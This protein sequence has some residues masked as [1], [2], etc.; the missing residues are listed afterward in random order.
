MDVQ[1]LGIVLVTEKH[2]PAMLNPDVLR[3]SGIIPIDWELARPPLYAQHLTQLVF[4]NGITLIAEANR[5]L[6]IE[7][8]RAK[9]S[10][11]IC[12]ARIARHYIERLP[13]AN[14]QNVVISLKGTAVMNEHLDAVRQYLVTHLLAPGAWQHF[15]QEP[16]RAS[17]NFTYTLENKRLNVSVSEAALEQSEGQVDPILLFVG[18]FA[19]PAS[20]H[21]VQLCHVI[22]HWQTDLKIFEDLINQRFLNQ[23]KQTWTVPLPELIPLNA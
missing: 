10:S 20:V 7:G 19:Y 5:I 2:T 15:G 18:T 1:E 8:I 3:C 17:L 11:N 13:H 21:P 6:F 14:Y 4:Q 9:A 22:E 12:I 23:E 16:V